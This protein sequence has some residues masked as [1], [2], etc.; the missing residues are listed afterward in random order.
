MKKYR[1]ALPA[2]IALLFCVLPAAVRAGDTPYYS[3]FDLMAPP[4]NPN[5]VMRKVDVEAALA[6]ERAAEAEAREDVEGWFGGSEEWAGH[7]VSCV[8]FAG[9]IMRGR[10]CGIKEKTSHHASSRRCSVCS[11]PNEIK[12]GPSCE[13]SAAPRSP[14]RCVLD[15]V[16]AQASQPCPGFP[17]FGVLPTLPRRD[18]VSGGVRGLGEGRRGG[19]FAVMG[20]KA[21]VRGKKG[22]SWHEFGG[23]CRPIL[24]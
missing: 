2:L 18:D 4:V 8:R 20:K 1:I 22:G 12:P 15:H 7:C 14:P 17:S 13:A 19:L 16:T 11:T 24:R 9:I 10:V 23:F 6:A 21:L 5:N 3:Q